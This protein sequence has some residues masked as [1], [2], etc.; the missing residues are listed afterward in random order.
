MTVRALAAILLVAGGVQ[1]GAQE[2]RVAPG[3]PP[4]VARS[5][6]ALLATPHRVIGPGAARALVSRDSS[7]P[8]SVVVLGRDAAVE[9]HVPGDV[10]V[11]GG[12]LYMHPG[13]HVDGR[14]VAIG[15]GAYPSTLATVTGGLTSDRDYTF[16]VTPGDGGYSLTYRP[17][18]VESAPAFDLA[19]FHGLLI[20]SYDR[21]DGLSVPIGVV[22]SLDTNSLELTPTVTYRTQLGAWDPA[23]GS[24]WSP[25]EDWTIALDAG[26]S[27]MSND[28]WIWSDLVN[29][30]SVIWAGI[31]TRNY[32][33][34][35]RAQLELRRTIELD[36]GNIEPFVGGRFERDWA[37]RPL[38]FV[39]GGP[40]SVLDRDNP[41][42]VVR[43]NPD[44]PSDHIASALAGVRLTWDEPT[45]RVV[46]S[47]MEELATASATESRFAQT[48]V[49]AEVTF[50]TYRTQTL[51]FEG[52][53][54]LTA[55]D[56]APVPRWGFV[57][58][59][60]TFRLIP[61]LSLGGDQLAY[62]E[63]NYTV[64]ID[65]LTL[66]YLGAPS[67]TLRHMMG[68]AGVGSLPGFEQ[69]LALRAALSVLRID[70]IYDVT[71]HKT[72]TG[73]GLSMTR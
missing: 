26:R 51:Q 14:A 52:H 24:V 60:G 16:A 35:D 56:Q 69:N 71:R 46:G 29:S 23:L 68:S 45:L 15:G 44:F 48:T 36:R 41:D 54:I 53:A 47:L 18:R 62:V 4:A 11:I 63:T 70:F 58:G 37:A 3:A 32:Y 59:A 13:A 25:N 34:S 67:L 22:V 5:V 61:L 66:P 72:G 28:R 30:L 57:G 1:L 21:T 55:G 39:T 6:A 50:P 9:G 65:R 33:R 38:G 27:T 10:V 8:G 64:P 43:P 7:Y 42:R 19:G 40:W 73:I 2:V 31:D 49:D 17:L 20:P 12:D